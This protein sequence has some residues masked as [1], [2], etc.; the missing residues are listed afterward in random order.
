M[1]LKNAINKYGVDNFDF[2]ILEVVEFTNKIDTI[3]VLTELEQKWF[4]IE[5]PYLKENGYNQNRTSKINVPIKRPEGYGELISKIKI[6]N[7]HCGKRV[8]QY[9]LNGEFIKE[10]KSAAEIERILGYKAENI[11]GCC[12]RRQ[13][14]SNGFIWRFHCNE[15]TESCISDANDSLRMSTVR[16]YNLKGDLLNVFDNILEAADITNISQHIIRSACNG[17]VKI[18]SG[19]IWK[20]KNQPLN[21]LNHISRKDYPLK[22]FTLSGNLVKEWDN[23]GEV[24]KVMNLTRHSSRHIYKCCQKE[25]ESYLSYKWEWGS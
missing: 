20:F 6:A 3:N 5:K 16:Q 7:N 9:D 15:L 14:S 18:G 24:I 10:W 17:S 19:F 12:L 13:N 23:V 21:L 8:K 11:S 4:D 2:D 1:I 25:K 22:Q